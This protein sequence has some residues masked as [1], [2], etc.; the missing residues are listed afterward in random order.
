MGAILAGASNRDLAYLNTFGVNLGIAFQMVD[1]HLGMYG[2]EHLLGKPVD[3]DIKEGK[4]TLHFAEGFRRANDSEREF[5]KSVW[6]NS[7]VT[8]IELDLTKAY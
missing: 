7:D 5:L 4:K 1:D 3:S 8:T 2:D 6:G